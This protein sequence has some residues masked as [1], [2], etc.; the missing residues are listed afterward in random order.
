[1]SSACAFLGGIGICDRENEPRF[2]KL[3][4][5]SFGR[6][7]HSHVSRTDTAAL[8]FDLRFSHRCALSSMPPPIRRPNF[9]EIVRYAKEGEDDEETAEVSLTIAGSE[10]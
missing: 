6:W 2:K 8:E 10:T 9:D 4:S 7:L 1:M 5:L 3:S